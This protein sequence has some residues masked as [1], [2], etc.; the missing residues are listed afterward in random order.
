MVLSRI[1]II[2][3]RKDQ[4]KVI[5]RKRLIYLT[6]LKI[7]RENSSKDRLIIQL[8]TEDLM[9]KIIFNQKDST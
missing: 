7:M 6:D 4:S 5:M 3:D 1:Y 8:I 9:V 2:K